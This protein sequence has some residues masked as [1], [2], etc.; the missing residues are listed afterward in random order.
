MW[1][2]K[3]KAHDQKEE[4]RTN[5]QTENKLMVARCE[6]LGGWVKKVKKTKRAQTEN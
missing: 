2:L 3:N 4:N 5:P 6:G 1:K